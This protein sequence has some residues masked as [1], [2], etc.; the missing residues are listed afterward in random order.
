MPPPPEL[1]GAKLNAEGPLD[2]RHASARPDQKPI[3][4]PIGDD[5]PVRLQMR[6]HRLLVLRR[7]SEARVVFVL[8][9]EV[10]V[11]RRRGILDILEKRFE[12]RRIAGLETHHDPMH[13]VGGERTDVRRFPGER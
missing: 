4:K 7:G 10:V 5:E 8:G 3:G 6:D 1:H 9:E 13:L 2:G 11:V 12:A